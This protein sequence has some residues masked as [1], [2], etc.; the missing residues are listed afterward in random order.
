MIVIGVDTGGTFTDFVYNDGCHW[1]VYKTLSTPSNPAEAVLNGM[2]HICGKFKSQV[3]LVHGSTV[4]TNTLLERKGALTALITNKGFEDVM[5]I[6]RQNRAELYHLS[7][8]DNPPLAPKHLRF[9][10][11][12]RIDHKGEILDPLNEVDIRALLNQLTRLEVESVAVS[13]LFSF[14]NPS[15]EQTV[16]AL[17]AALDVPVSL[18]HNILNEFREFERT[19]TTLVNAY[20]SPVMN[21]Y[22]KRLTR[23][24]KTD[25][26]RIMQSNGGSISAETAM[27]ESVRTILSG[28]AGGVVGAYE[29]GKAAGFNHLITFDMGGTSTD[30]CL[31]ED[32]LPL[33]TESTIAGYPVKVPMIDIHTVGAGGGSIAYGDAGGALKVGPESA[34]ADPGPICFGKGRRITVTD[35]NLFLGRLIAD[36]FLGGGMSLDRTRLNAFFEAMA[37]RFHLTPVML[38]EGILDIANTAMERAV[39]VIS[40]EKGLDPKHF[41]LFSFGGAGGMHAVFLARMLH[42]PQVLIPRN[43]GILSAWGMLMSDIVK[44]Y[45]QTV[46]LP[47]DHFL[48]ADLEE[49]FRPLEQQAVSDLEAEGMHPSRVTMI[50]GLDMRYRG[51]SHEIQVPF[52][53]QLIEGFHRLHEKTYG[54][55]RHQAPVEI[56]NIRLRAVGKMQ[57]PSLAQGTFQQ[58]VPASKYAGIDAVVDERPVVFEGCA[59]MTPVMER[60]QLSCS[61]KITG[62]AIIVEYSSTVVLPPGCTGR[63][64]AYGNLIIMVEEA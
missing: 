10:I 24:I 33:T 8:R 49:R 62:P 25:N 36:R 43:P 14:E 37:D 21:A 63:V 56:V 13:F 3:R 32:A 12:C 6:G 48:S 53:T 50:R 4:A 38:A 44:D 52:G 22:L 40:V 61:Q 17:L 45:S 27:R 58:Q 39:R 46:M 28:P 20:V 9:G 15:H 30:V 2:A 7:C 5:D 51:Q 60:E 11:A 19:S 47:G 16:G 18:S 55:C 59:V 26:L 57:K 1:Q 54:Y 23:Q 64:D 42:I 34:G 29:I 41:S 35:A 31:I